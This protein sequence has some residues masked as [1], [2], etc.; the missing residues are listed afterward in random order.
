MSF[1]TNES[2]TLTVSETMPC[3]SVCVVE[4]TRPPA[5]STMS[6]RQPVMSVVLGVWISPSS[7]VG[8]ITAQ[9]VSITWPSSDKRI[10]CAG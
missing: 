5:G 10:S 8:L 1:H 2:R 3:W 7:V 4:M 6:R 9:S